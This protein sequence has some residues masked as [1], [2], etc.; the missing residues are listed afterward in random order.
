M[1]KTHALLLA[2]LFCLRVHSALAQST[3]SLEGKVT[4]LATGEALPGVNV[5]V[6]GTVLGAATD[7][8]GYFVIQRIPPGTYG[9]QVTMIGYKRAQVTARVQAE[10]ATALMIALEETILETPEVMVTANKRRQSIQ[11]TPNSVGVLT[12][13]DIEQ[14]NQIYIDQFLQQASG[15]NFV[16]SQVNIRGSSGF[17]YGAGS[18]VL[19]LIDG[20][21]AMPGD[22]GD[23]KWDMI[24][25]SQI[26]RVEIIKGAGSALY[27][28]SALGGVINI[29]TKKASARPI[30][31]LR[32]SAGA[33]DAPAH[34]EWKWSDELRHFSDIDIDHTRKIGQKSE[35]LAAVGRHQS[36]G[37]RQNT[38]QLRHNASFK[39]N[40]KPTGTHNLTLSTNWEGGDRQ[41]GL[42][43]RSQRQAL[44]VSPEA[45]GDYVQ[46]NKFSANLF[47][48]WVITKNLGLQTRASYF[49]NYWKNWF[50]DNI[51]ASKAQKPGVEIQGDWQISAD[52]S[53]IFGAEGSWDY[54]DSDLVG[55]HD[56]YVI[57][58]YVQNERPLITNLNMTL[59]VRYDYAWVDIGF[60]DSEFNPKI[61]LVWHVQRDIRLRAS[62]GRGFRAASMSERFADSIYSGLRII[63]NP[64]LQSETSWSQEIGVNFTP[65]SRF[66]I[67]VAGFMNDYWDLI[68][69]EPNENQVVQFI[70]ITR[71]RIT[72]VETTL[73]MLPYTNLSFDLGYT[74]MDPQDLDLDETL[75]YRPRHLFT[76][77][78]TYSIGDFECGADLRYISRFDAVKVYPHDDRVD[79][80]LVNLRG[81][82]RIGA[83][84]LTMSLNNVFNHN[85]TQMERTLMPIRHL[86]LTLSSKF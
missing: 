71:A 21:P 79:Q 44:Q 34:P 82:Y 60:I 74:W 42:M 25:A 2:I 8:D 28:S 53:L 18:R 3:G 63:P 69:P 83:F 78:I 19:F 64:E 54:V 50:H 41:T 65:S 84:A 43:W 12:S 68:E 10:E 81:V 32:L 17:S 31:N 56:Q 59:G 9:I 86:V 29:I 1:K 52:N 14:K 26:E 11:D 51:T 48:N 57:G 23:I 5:T 7:A 47:H 30:T 72:G 27:G 20:V 33:Y 67:D 13:R 70:N 49:Y 85:H 36:M 6:I 39:W 24:P 35:I 55:A 75:A 37:Y 58:A 61:G 4:D 66:Y 80:K 22:S 45:L 16:G 77:G 73:K 76:G 38:E 40:Y 46:S 15:V 62:S